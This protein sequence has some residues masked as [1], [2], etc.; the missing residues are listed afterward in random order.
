MKYT[1]GIDIGGTKIT[2]IVWD[3]KKIVDQLTIVTP[4]NLFEF[5]RNLLKLVDFLAA[6]KKI[7]GLGVGA[8][9]LVDARKGI[10]RYSPNIRFLNNFRLADVL[11]SRGVKRVKVD[12]DAN[13][14][15]RAELL[16]GQG[17][18]FSDFLALTLGTGIGGGIVINRRLY[19]GARNNGA[20]LGHIVIDGDFLESHF[21]KARDRKDNQE[22]GQVLGQAFA[23]LANIF[24]PEAIILGGGV[25][26]DRR[27][28]FLKP[29]E[30]TMQKF[31]FDKTV[32]PKI[33]VSQLTNAGALGAALL[34]K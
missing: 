31:L 24:V 32:A 25:S 16:L 14:F 34:V 30:Q 18:K 4:K 7:G 1:I 3:G 12:N 10:I 6:S 29:A 19:R 21:K 22:L 11:R 28:H 9:G 17:K 13:C 23:G 26:T 33:L 5:Q 15:T 20:E 8:A 27:R 2:G